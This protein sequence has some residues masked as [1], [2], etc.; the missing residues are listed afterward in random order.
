M[1]ETMFREQALTSGVY[2]LTKIIKRPP[3]KSQAV[4]EID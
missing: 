2:K 4:L 1:H 3:L